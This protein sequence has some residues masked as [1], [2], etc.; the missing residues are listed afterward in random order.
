MAMML[1]SSSVTLLA[2]KACSGSYG[3]GGR[4]QVQRE[5]RYAMC[6]YSCSLPSQRPVAQGFLVF[7][8]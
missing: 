3:D 7:Q 8:S 6:Q 1:V 5:R 2:P 4:L